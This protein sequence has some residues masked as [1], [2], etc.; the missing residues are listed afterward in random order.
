MPLFVE[1]MK[2]SLP[3]SMQID[4][5]LLNHPVH[6]YLPCGKTADGPGFSWN[7]S[8]HLALTKAGLRFNAR[9]KQE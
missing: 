2:V 5:V 3:Q 9:S 1:K 4:H 7:Q 6:S 8:I